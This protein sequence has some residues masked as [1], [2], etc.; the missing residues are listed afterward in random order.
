MNWKARIAMA[1]GFPAL[2]CIGAW[3]GGFDF[4][5]RGAEASEV[6]LWSV[7]LSVVGLSCPMF[8]D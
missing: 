1:L 2:I 5:E 4:N 7:A 3:L 8:D 6:F